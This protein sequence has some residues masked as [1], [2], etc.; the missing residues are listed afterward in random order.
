MHRVFVYGTL[1]QGFCN[2][3]INR[4]RR[5]GGDFVTVHRHALFIIGED[6]LPWLVADPPAGEGHPVVGQLFEVDNNTLASMDQLERVAEPMWYQRQAIAVSP[7][8]RG[9]ACTA[10]VY[11][12]NR[13]RMAQERVH[14][15]PVAEYTQALA[16]AYPLVP[17]F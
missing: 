9:P 7:V 15:G 8:E 11:L 6:N 13:E 12:G 17:G 14:A 3:H 5:V 16:A 4:G 2:F 10:W 1:K